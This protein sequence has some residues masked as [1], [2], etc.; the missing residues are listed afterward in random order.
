M[1]GFEDGA[2]VSDS[3]VELDVDRSLCVL[4]GAPND[5]VMAKRA[6]GIAIDDPCWCVSEEFPK[7]L[8]ERAT[9]RD[10][11]A[12]CICLRCLEANR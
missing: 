3:V 7:A 8:S 4:C 2:P 10:G 5:C 6:T 9:E 1:L 11:G 12:S